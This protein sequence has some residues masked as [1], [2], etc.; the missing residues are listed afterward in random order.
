VLPGGDGEQRV[1]VVPGGVL[2]VEE[3]PADGLVVSQV[4]LGVGASL[5]HECP[6]RR[7]SE[8]TAKEEPQHQAVSRWCGLYRGREQLFQARRA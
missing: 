8:L 2:F 3:V 6:A 7:P 4:A 5:T 1:G